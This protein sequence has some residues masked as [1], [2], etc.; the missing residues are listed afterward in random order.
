MRWKS[1]VA[2]VLLSLLAAAPAFAQ[3]VASSSITGVVVDNSD[4]ARPRIV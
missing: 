1:L 2:A 4:L 3:G